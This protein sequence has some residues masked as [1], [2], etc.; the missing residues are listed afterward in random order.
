MPP[1][2]ARR[3]PAPSVAQLFYA[4]HYAE[5]VRRWVDGVEEGNSA[6]FPFLVGALAFVG[7]LEEARALF[8]GHRR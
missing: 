4:G 3:A 8:S 2:K 5:I 1:K 7:R 6:D